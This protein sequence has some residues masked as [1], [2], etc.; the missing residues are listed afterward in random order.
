MGMKGKV[1]A[2]EIQSLYTETI[3]PK[4]SRRGGLSV[5]AFW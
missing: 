1:E 5:R 2:A 3:L 4:V